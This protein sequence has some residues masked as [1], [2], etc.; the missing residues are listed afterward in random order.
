M[1]SFFFL[2][3]RMPPRSTRTDTLFPFTTLFLSPPR[4]PRRHRRPHPR[5][6]RRDRGD[7][8]R[9]SDLGSAQP[10]YAEM[11]DLAHGRQSRRRYRARRGAA[12]R[13]RL[14]I[15]LSLEPDRKTVV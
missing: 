13:R 12:R 6:R 9:L 14:R 8:G 7:D 3:I 2:M 5:R 1:T 10:R 11:E 15:L 4:R